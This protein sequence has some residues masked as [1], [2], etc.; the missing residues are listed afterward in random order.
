MTKEIIF[1]DNKGNKY[2]LHVGLSKEEKENILK[3]SSLV[4]EQTKDL[5]FIEICNLL[6]PVIEQEND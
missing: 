3:L 6:F 5:S 1:K 4:Q 2:V